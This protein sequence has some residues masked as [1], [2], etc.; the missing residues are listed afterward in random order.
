MEL[1]VV[2][3][4]RGGMGEGE[5]KGSVWFH[6]RGLGEEEMR[7]CC[8]RDGFIAGGW[9]REGMVLAAI[10]RCSVLTNRFCCMRP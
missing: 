6:R 4:L 10:A 9:E 1:L 3:D 8:Y 7:G 5:M 2:S